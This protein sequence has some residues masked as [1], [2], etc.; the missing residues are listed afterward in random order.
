MDVQTLTDSAPV[1]IALGV[2]VLIQLHIFS[3]P[4]DLEKKHKTIMD[5]V[6][7]KYVSKE[8]MSYL[9]EKVDKMDGKIDKIYDKIIVEAE[10]V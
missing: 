1:I 7:K 3:S 2:V 9:R 8:N 5:E 10:H 6:D 4:A